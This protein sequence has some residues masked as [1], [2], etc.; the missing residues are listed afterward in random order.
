M[1]TVI[2]ILGQLESVIRKSKNKLLR[3]K[4]PHFSAVERWY[5]EDARGLKRFEFDFLTPQSVV[6]DLGGYL[7]EWTS[8]LFSR[9]QPRI[10]IFEPVKE[11]AGVIAKRFAH[12]SSIKVEQAGLAPASAVTRITLDEFESKVVGAKHPVLNTEEIRLIGIKDYFEKEGL[13]KVDLVKINIEG[14]EYDLLE[15][16]FE[17]GLIGKIDNFLIQFHT[18]E[19]DAQSRRNA[20]RKKFSADFE[21]VYNYPFVWECWKRK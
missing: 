19:R 1:N 14:A 15:Y 17:S 2:N 10:Y 7:G 18:W 3:K 11:Y 16:L 21:E 6:I 8:G 13:Q 4:D 9:Y 12:N 5:T 20:L